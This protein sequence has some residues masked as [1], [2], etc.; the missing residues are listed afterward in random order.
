M[1]FNKYSREFVE[2]IA[3]YNFKGII[4]LHTANICIKQ[5]RSVTNRFEDGLSEALISLTTEQQAKFLLQNLE[6]FASLDF[7]YSE[8]PHYTNDIDFDFE[9]YL[10]VGEL[11][12]LCYSYAAGQIEN[13]AIP[14][15]DVKLLQGRIASSEIGYAQELT[16]RTY[17]LKV[18]DKE[19]DKWILNPD[20]RE[21]RLLKHQDSS[22]TQSDKLLADINT[23]S[24]PWQYG[25]NDF[26]EMLYKLERAGAIDLKAYFDSG[27]TG[28]DLARNF[29]R[30]FAFQSKAS[31]PVGTLSNYISDIRKGLGRGGHDLGILKSIG[32]VRGGKMDNI[33]PENPKKE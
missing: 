2:A 27:G 26:A 11:Q 13:Q 3:P 32:R 22:T 21:Y 33:I 15:E 5:A 4:D 18:G 25:L 17:A 1:L 28:S 14:K 7:L 24:L 31:N 16:R 29:C 12:V 10:P 30:L 8:D 6:N 20:I 23:I 9:K 19:A